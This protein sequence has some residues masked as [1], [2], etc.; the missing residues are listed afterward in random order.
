MIEQFKNDVLLGLSSEPKFLSSKYFYDKIGDDLFIKIM[1]SDEYYL[2]RS[3]FEIFNE[4]T[5][6][7][8]NSLEVNKKKF[9]EIIELGAGDGT[10]T[11]Q[12]LK[13]LD[14]K[15]YNFK[16]TPIDIS[17]NALSK[18]EISLSK[19][20]PNLIVKPTQGDYFQVLKSIKNLEYKKVVLFLGSNIG[21]LNDNLSNQFLNELGEILNKNDVL[22]L[23]VDLIK[24]EKIVLPA[25]ND[26]EGLT[27]RFNLNLLRRINEELG[28]NFDLSK[29]IHRPEY[30]EV[31]GVAKSYLESLE[32]QS[33]TIESINKVFHFKLG[34]RIHTEISRKYNDDIINVILKN[35]NFTVKEKLM[36]SKNYFANYILRKY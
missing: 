34:E 9:F 6:Q 10:K 29:F 22:I 15:G 1:N 20:F 11:K 21:N 28:G 16:Y 24:D 7:I 8:I 36:D 26:S 23:G 25:Y 17:L 27:S 33:I 13:A 4:K 35:T 3:E 32:N 19:D 18:L 31:E 14:I 12:L 2:T 5:N 30:N